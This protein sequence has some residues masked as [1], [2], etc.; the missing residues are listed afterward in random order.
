[1]AVAVRNTSANGQDQGGVSGLREKQA[2]ER[3]AES[4]WFD[5]RVICVLPDRG[6]IGL[7][8]VAC[9]FIHNCLFIL[10]KLSSPF[11]RSLVTIRQ[12]IFCIL[13]D[14]LFHWFGIFYWE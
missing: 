2:E 8:V 6:A 4:S 7:N 5:S 11:T 10:L 14:Y 12:Q 13:L 1:M 3:D 9:I